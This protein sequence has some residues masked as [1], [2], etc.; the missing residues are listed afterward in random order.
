MPISLDI[1]VT[2]LRDAAIPG[3]LTSLVEDELAKTMRPFKPLVKAS[4]LNIPTEGPKH[5]GLRLRLA[6]CV[7]TFAKIESTE[8]CRVGIWMQVDKM[9]SGQL[10]LPLTMEGVKLW[11]HPVYGKPPTVVQE[12]HEYFYSALSGL[13]AASEKAVERAVERIGAIM[14]GRF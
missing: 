5:T 7:E 4:I 11:L 10:A 14:E 6:R 2:G 12:P 13:G 9:P 1:V 3:H 8:E